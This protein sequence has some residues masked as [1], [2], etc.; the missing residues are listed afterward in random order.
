M[1]N[2]VNNLQ[3]L[4]KLINLD[5]FYSISLFSGSEISLQGKATQE[6]LK[7]LSI[8]CTNFKYENTNLIGHFKHEDFV[9][10]VVLTF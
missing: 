2:K 4:A 9:Y 5:L 1:E 3:E 10:R 8:I 6:A 7:E